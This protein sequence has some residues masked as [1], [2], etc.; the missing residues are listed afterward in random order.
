MQAWHDIMMMHT[1]NPHLVKHASTTNA[2]LPHCRADATFTNHL[3]VQQT[4]CQNALAKQKV[5]KCIIS[6]ASH[7]AIAHRYTVLGSRIWLGTGHPCSL[8]LPEPLAQLICTSHLGAKPIQTHS[9]IPW[10]LAG[11]QS[12]NALVQAMYAVYSIGH[13]VQEP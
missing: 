12:A 3:T 13:T 8:L 5:E 9:A 2:C 11:Q 10:C 7:K 1:I 4:G 6:Q